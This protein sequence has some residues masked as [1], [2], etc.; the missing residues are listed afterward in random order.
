M[1]IVLSLSSTLGWSSQ[2]SDTITNIASCFSC[3]ISDNKV[4]E[5]TQVWEGPGE[6]GYVIIEGPVDRQTPGYVIIDGPGDRETSRSAKTKRC[7]A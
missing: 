3:S 1:N 2:T 5:L 4:T 6:E 7:L